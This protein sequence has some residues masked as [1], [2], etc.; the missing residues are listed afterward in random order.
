VKQETRTRERRCGNLASR[1]Y[2]H[3]DD[4]RCGENRFETENC[5]WDDKASCTLDLVSAFGQARELEQFSYLSTE[6]SELC[7]EK[8]TATKAATVPSYI[9]KVKGMYLE[10]KNSASTDADIYICTIDKVKSEFPRADQEYC[11]LKRSVCPSG[12]TETKIFSKRFSNIDL[13]CNNEI[14]PTKQLHLSGSGII[15][16]KS[17]KCPTV[18]GK[19]TITAPL[20]D[21]H[22]TDVPKLSLCAYGPM[23]KNREQV[24]LSSF[25]DNSNDN[26]LTSTPTYL[27]VVSHALCNNEASY[28][29][30]ID[31]VCSV[32]GGKLTTMQNVEFTSELE[33]TDS[34]V[35]GICLDDV[36][37]KF[38]AFGEIRKSEVRTKRNTYNI[39]REQIEQLTENEDSEKHQDRPLSWKMEAD[40]TLLTDE[41]KEQVKKHQEVEKAMDK[42]LPATSPGFAC[43]H[44]TNSTQVFRFVKLI[45]GEKNSEFSE[46]RTLVVKTNRKKRDSDCNQAEIQTFARHKYKGLVQIDS[47]CQCDAGYGLN[48][49]QI[50]VPCSELSS[51]ET[52]HNKQ[53]KSDLLILKNQCTNDA[54][55]LCT[56][57][58]NLTGNWENGKCSVG[59]ILNDTIVIE[60]TRRAIRPSISDFE[61]V[62]TS[63]EN[64]LAVCHDTDGA[65]GFGYLK[66]YE[67]ELSC[68][69]GGR[70]YK[71]FQV[72]SASENNWSE[73]S[74]CVSGSQLRKRP[75]GQKQI[76]DCSYLNL[77]QEDYSLVVLLNATK[78]FLAFEGF[79]Q[80]PSHRAVPKPLA[81][82]KNNEI[83]HTTVTESGCIAVTNLCFYEPNS[84]VGVRT[85]YNDGASIYNFDVLEQK[86]GNSTLYLISIDGYSYSIEYYEETDNIITTSNPVYTKDSD[87]TI[88]RL[89]IHNK[90]TV[91]QHKSTFACE[92][93][94]GFGY[95]KFENGQ[96]SCYFVS[97]NDHAFK[98]TETDIYNAKTLH[99][100][101]PDLWRTF[102]ILDNYSFLMS[103]LEGRIPE[104]SN[105]I[106]NEEGDMLA[107]CLNQNEQLFGTVRT[108][109]A[110]CNYVGKEGE[111]KS[112]IHYAVVIGQMD[113]VNEI[114]EDESDAEE[115]FQKEL[116]RLKH[117][118]DNDKAFENSIFKSLN[119]ERAEKHMEQMAEFTEKAQDLDNLAKTEGEKMELEAAGAERV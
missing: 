97:G 30:F 3:K 99:P 55:E 28:G 89:G 7:S 83:C 54:F 76:K 14:D 98:I 77:F 63:T 108:Y 93:K 94:Y 78:G 96:T 15:F 75:D 34:S 116:D 32:T 88:V 24:Y 66:V 21:A 10:N 27:P 115:E 61:I 106:T 1:Q 25:G 37:G 31:G 112:S 90:C 67:E 9:T 17:L 48:A 35:P 62:E 53:T 95:T 22:G 56:S 107:V 46:Y 117:L 57:Y 74:D 86:E 23:H 111:I 38:I 39:Q 79:D 52:V 100:E 114:E 58:E 71:K 47:T 60:T 44:G 110:G 69:S 101:E 33:E 103:D 18:F 91:E 29:D 109:K 87:E 102:T 64:G 19:T 72:I 45:T 16:S 113:E 82:G 41:E 118:Q 11:V 119:K 40:P 50:C 20:F 43:Y 84:S 68:I 49:D 5:P 65:V 42:R 70:M 51:L 80:P 6:A 36:T 81:L 73:W 8:L 92:S 4:K 12:L 59:K 105:A 85:G 2:L 26:L 104:V 13:C